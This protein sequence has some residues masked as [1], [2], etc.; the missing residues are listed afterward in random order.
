MVKVIPFEKSWRYPQSQR[1]KI[2]N[3]AYDFLFR[4]NHQGGFCV[5]SVTRVEDQAIVFNGK[6]VRLN[7]ITAKD[8][9]THEE[10]FYLLPYEITDS[11]AEVW[12]FYD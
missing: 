3:V 2:N 10:L 6:L 8:P 11:K 1:V 12:V 9:A 5:L 4:W 7:P